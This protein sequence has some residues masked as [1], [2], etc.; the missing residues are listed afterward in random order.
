MSD[1]INIKLSM[2]TMDKFFIR[3]AIFKALNASVDDFSGEF[4]DV[5]CGKMPYK[6]FILDNSKV[7]NYTGLDIDGAIVYDERVKPDFT[8]DGRVMP[9][10]DNSFDSVMATEVLEH[11]PDPTIVL[12]EI[13]RVLKP[14]GKLFFTVP[15][16]WNLHEV[17]YDEYRYTPFAL[18]RLMHEA[19]FNSVDIRATGGWHASMAQ[20]LGLW[21]I[22]SDMSVNIRRVLK[23]VSLPLYK[24]LLKLDAPPESFKETTMVPSLYGNCTV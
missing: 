8:W 4:L 20:M 22:R 13:V 2:N 16:I 19:G 21:L 7:E 3:N 23:V 9:F 17:P 12:K 24:L 11:C 15:F 10:E 14:G 5:G 1:F 18:E 6:T